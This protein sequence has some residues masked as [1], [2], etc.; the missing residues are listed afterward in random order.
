VGEPGQ[1]VSVFVDYAHTDDALANVLGALRPIT[2]GALWVVVGCGGE[3]DR[4][5]RPRMAATADR[6]ADRVVLTSDN[7]RRGSPEAILEEMLS[8]LGSG[9]R[10]RVRV[11]PDRRRA[12]V[13]SVAG[14][15]AG[16]V[17]LIAGKGHETV[18]VVGSRRLPFDDRQVAAEA[19]R[20]RK[21]G[22]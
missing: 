6:L 15:E 21:A 22:A 14:A 9:S 17:V 2:S 8:G 7:P 5:K 3:R 13:E 12:I 11:E 4:T 18:Q 10:G 19:L 20:A 1:A 16:D